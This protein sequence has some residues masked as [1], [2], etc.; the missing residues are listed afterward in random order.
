MKLLSNLLES[1]HPRTLSFYPADTEEL[2]KKNLKT[3]S[4]DWSWRT[5]PI[6]YSLNRQGFRCGEFDSLDWNNSILAFGCS[7]TFGV[8]VDDSDTWPSRLSQFIMN[9]VI[10]LAQG[11]QGWGFNWVN[12]VRVIEAGHRPKAVIYYW[13]TT[14]RM[15]TLPDPRNPNLVLGHGS[16][17]TEKNALTLDTKLG[18]YWV[19]DPRIGYFWAQQY[20]LSLDI[21]WGQLGVPVYHF[22]WVYLQPRQ[23]MEYIP[24][25]LNPKDLTLRARDLAHPG[26]T[27]CIRIALKVRIALKDLY[28]IKA[29]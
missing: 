12:S 18:L 29:G 20:R 23:D 8:G 27:D 25:Y 21:M 10:N 22:T 2:Y 6:K 5:R 19:M 15:F 9:P 26:P 4:K 28:P 3:Q 16:W 24:L 11:G 14:E 17:T 7:N 13:P 1:D